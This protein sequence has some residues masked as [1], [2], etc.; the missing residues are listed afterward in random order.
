MNM[1]LITR[2]NWSQIL[3]RMQ[4]MWE[5][6][7]SARH[8][9]INFASNAYIQ[10]SSSAPQPNTSR[11]PGIWT[12]LSWPPCRQLGSS[13]GEAGKA[14][15]PWCAGQRAT[16]WHCGAECCRLLGVSCRAGDIADLGGNG[17][18][19]VFP[20]RVCADAKH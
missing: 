4:Y 19:R 18:L 20:A 11:T 7:Y 9:R 14:Y 17:E 13:M 5:L 8:H 10:H 12:P 6:A 3:L 1:P 2:H 16:G 15:S